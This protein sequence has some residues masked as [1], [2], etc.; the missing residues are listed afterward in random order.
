MNIIATKTVSGEVHI[1][2]YFKHP[3]KPLNDEVKPDLKL[4]G[5]KREGF[6]LA[7]NPVRPGLLL[8]GSDDNLVCL[9]DVNAPNQLSST[10]EATQTYDAHTQVVED[11]C[12]NHFNE[13]SFASVSDDRRLLLWDMR[14]KEPTN[15]IEAHMQE[16]MCVD[17]SPFDPNLLITGSADRSIAVWDTRN[18]KCKLFSLRHHKDE[19]TQ[20][21]FSPMHGNL[22]ASS[23]SDRRV[24]V[25]DLSRIDKP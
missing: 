13:F 4:L 14:Q 1:F 2:D 25:W 6:G 18:V 15:N 8:S 11:V 21:R 7:W 16:I 23:S 9:W 22:I 24:M 10:L 3:S 5:H 17:A 20:I 12:W 19:V